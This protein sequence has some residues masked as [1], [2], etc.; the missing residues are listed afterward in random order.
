MKKLPLAFLIILLFTFPAGFAAATDIY[1][2][3]ITNITMRTGPGVSHKIVAMLKS[4]TKL[5]IMD[6]QSDW[7]QV[8][9]AGG[10]IGWVLTRFLT[11]KVPDALLVEK[12]QKQNEALQGKLETLEDENRNLTVKNATLVQVEEKYNKLKKESSDFL[13]LDKQ[14]KELLKLYEAQ[15]TQ[16]ESIEFDSKKEIKFWLLIGPAVFLVG[17]FFGL[18]SRKKKRSSLL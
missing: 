1:V 2:T 10:N 16:I 15:K 13:K 3:G 4:G 11:E 8:K 12:L 6:Y 18:G 17:L 14:Y 5:E 9:T 7:S